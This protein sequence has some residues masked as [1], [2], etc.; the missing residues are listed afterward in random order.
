MLRERIRKKI[1][2]KVGPNTIKQLRE[3]RDKN[4][5]NIENKGGLV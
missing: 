3:L 5:R 1:E 2:E 4:R